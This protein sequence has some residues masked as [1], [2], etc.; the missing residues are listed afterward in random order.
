MCANDGMHISCS[1][2]VSGVSDENS[3]NTRQNVQRNMV[4]KGDVMSLK[5]C[6]FIDFFIEKDTNVIA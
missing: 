1:V 6:F 3:V 2:Q 4:L 5:S